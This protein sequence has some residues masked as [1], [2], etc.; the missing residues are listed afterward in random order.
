MA[1]A[2]R[3]RQDS[4]VNIPEYAKEFEASGVEEKSVVI[5]AID[6][7]KQAYSSFECEYSVEPLLGVSKNGLCS[8]GRCNS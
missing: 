8:E 3:R 6:W 4:Y 2:L 1:G 7:S 5:I